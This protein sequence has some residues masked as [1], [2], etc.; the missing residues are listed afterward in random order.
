MDLKQLSEAQIL[1]DERHGF[2]VKFS[3]PRAKYEQL[4]KDLVGL[5]GE[6][7]EFANVVKKIN[8]KLERPTEYELNV[9]TA[10]ASLRE[11]LVDS[12]IYVIRMAAI[13]EIDI[14]AEMLKKMTVNESRYAQL[15]R[16]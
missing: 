13:L 9:D 2:P 16:R 3:N 10:E 14:E 6:I 15:R 7:G 5:F 1:M 4:T 8:I 12:L 11:E